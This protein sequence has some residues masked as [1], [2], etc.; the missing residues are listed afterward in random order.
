MS[1]RALSTVWAQVPGP[2]PG[3]WE[4]EPRLA[5]VPEPPLAVVAEPALAAVPAP[6]LDPQAARTP[7]T[8]S[9]TGAHLM[10]EAISTA[11]IMH[12]NPMWAVI[13]R[14]DSSHS[15]A[16]GGSPVR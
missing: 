13:G 7:A 10:I 16:A 11:R 2:S 12:G 14:L 6:P 8:P 1:P 5:L 4:T 3:G 15:R 9:T